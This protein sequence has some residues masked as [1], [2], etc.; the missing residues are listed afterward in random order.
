MHTD[1]LVKQNYMREILPNVMSL[2][3]GLVWLT[4]NLTVIIHCLSRNPFFFNVIYPVE[5]CLL[6]CYAVWLL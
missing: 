5:W 1:I 3:P 2:R 6:G 4:P